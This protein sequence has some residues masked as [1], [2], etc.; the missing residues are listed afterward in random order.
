MRN[1][2]IS[3]GCF[4]LCFALLISHA[5]GAC[6]VPN[7]VTIKEDASG[8][9][10]N[11]SIPIEETFTWNIIEVSGHPWSTLSI[12]IRAK[13]QEYFLSNRNNVSVS[14]FVTKPID[15]ESL[16][17]F[18]G[19]VVTNVKLRISCGATSTVTDMIVIVES[20][21][22]FPPEFGK[23]YYH[24]NVNESTA[25]GSLVYTISDVTDRDID[26]ADNSLTYTISK[27]LEEF[28]GT[29]YFGMESGTSPNIMLQK[30]VDYDA[31]VASGKIP[32]FL[33]R[34]TVL[35]HGGRRDDALFNFTI[36]NEDDLPPAFIIPNCDSG[37]TPSYTTIVPDGFRGALTNVTPAALKAVDQDK[38]HAVQYSLLNDSAGYHSAFRIDPNTGIISALSPV[39]S[40]VALIVKVTEIS[41]L[42]RFA[43]ANMLVKTNSS[44][45]SQ[46]NVG[47]SVVKE[48]DD[49]MTIIV[50]VV[51]IVAVI[52][53][54]A[55]VLAL[56]IYCK[57]QREKMVKPGDVSSSQSTSRDALQNEKEL[58]NSR[59][60]LLQ[61]YAMF[62]TSSEGKGNAL[63]PIT[64]ADMMIGTDEFKKRSRKRR[65]KEQEIFDGTRKYDMEA[66]IDFFRQG[67]KSKIKRST[68]SI[69]EQ[70][71]DPKYWITVQNGY[72]E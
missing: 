48:T 71:L 61:S 46:P 59:Q 34:V 26:E 12:E 33:I 35:D 14:I 32:T 1:L 56:V 4:L 16:L 53:I 60:E 21:N 50:I 8:S 24:I 7:F 20:V 57:R 54:G 3:K 63:P 31:I 40:T 42:Q 49:N 64:T 70:R 15:K 6:D 62:M 69:K 18:I 47:R 25:V 58:S 41:A 67:T 43:L 27:D 65:K 19:L 13:I 38:Q 66:D 9:I 52:I 37:C 39:L 28:D 45:G 51:A 68:R 29:P 44:S 2:G 17:D 5:Q 23:N 10:L 72:L 55:L 36:I 11:N 22:E 30:V